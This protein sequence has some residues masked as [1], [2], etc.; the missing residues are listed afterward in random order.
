LPG[1]PIA[2]LDQALRE[3]RELRNAG[4][5]GL[6]VRPDSLGSDDAK[7]VAERT[8]VEQDATETER[9]LNDVIAAPE[10]AREAIRHTHVDVH[11]SR[12]IRDVRPRSDDVIVEIAYL[13]PSIT[14]SGS[15][16]RNRLS[17]H[18]N[19]SL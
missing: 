15:G 9:P 7:P 14:S 1:I 6:A 8:R 18:A 4:E 17:A 13:G 16:E 10:L 5:L 2:H 12:E 11:V 19:R 3:P